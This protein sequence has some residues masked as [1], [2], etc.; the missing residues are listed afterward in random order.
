MLQQQ[1]FLRTEGFWPLAVVTP[2][3]FGKSGP[4]YLPGDFAGLRLRS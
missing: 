1:L 2:F 3:T 4:D